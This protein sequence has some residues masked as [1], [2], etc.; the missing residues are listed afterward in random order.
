VTDRPVTM[1]IQT[2]PA[3]ALPMIAEDMGFF[4]D[5]G[6]DVELVQFTAGKF[7]MQAFLAGSLDL[8]VS[9]DV[10]VALSAMEGNRFYVI[11]QVVEA[12]KNEVR[13]VARAEPGLADAQSYFQGKR[14]RLATS[15]GGGPEFYT[16]NFLRKHNITDVE[17]ISQKPEDM[18]VSLDSHTVDAIAIFDPHAYFA[19]QRLGDKGVTFTDD[20]LYSELY[21]LSAKTEWVEADPERS[22]KILRALVKASE[23]A[24]QDPDGAKAIVMRYTHLDRKTVDGIWGDFVFRPALNRILPTY[25]GQEAQWAQDTGKVKAGTATPDFGQYIYS[26]PLRDV[27]PDAVAL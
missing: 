22:R 15:F 10:P 9:G 3:N 14:R 6:V 5:E 4:E 24:E 16:Y 8:A 17:I 18:P 1:G 25:L 23:Y 19:Q 12:T 27:K 11:S 13:I 20:S 21:V 26:Q 2:G 7:A